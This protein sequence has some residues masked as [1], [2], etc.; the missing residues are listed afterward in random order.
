MASKK[1]KQPQRKTLEDLRDKLEA[2]PSPPAEKSA[3]EKA[4]TNE[5]ARQILVERLI[6]EA[7]ERGEFDNLPGKGKPLKF[8]ENPYLE[9]GQEWAFGLLKRNDFA[10]EWI[11]RDK[12]IRK[13]IAEMRRQLH[14]AWQQRQNNPANESKWQVALSRFEERLTKLNRKID[15]FNLVV[16]VVSLQRSRL[17]LADELRRLEKAIDTKS[18]D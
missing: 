1:H 14:L 4:K 18:E 6:Q 17:R 10:P 2:A 13:E 3:S 8:D 15:A 7:M 9:P 12:E 16:P 11:E 5:Q